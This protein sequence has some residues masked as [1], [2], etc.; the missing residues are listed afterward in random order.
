LIE[1]IGAKETVKNQDFPQIVNF[2]TE[3]AT[4]D[5]TGKIIQNIDKRASLVGTDP[6]AEQDFLDYI[7]R[8][9]RTHTQ[10]NDI[11]KTFDKNK[12][13][14]AE[15]ANKNA[16]KTKSSASIP[17]GGGRK[18][19]SEDDLTP[20]E[21]AMLTKEQWIKLRPETTKRLSMG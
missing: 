4:Q 8:V 6:E 16:S 14:R 18:L 11:G 20:E 12:I 15:K 7:Y 5:T 10:F 19:I 1:D 17:S 21:G 13:E 9:A 2:V 3:L